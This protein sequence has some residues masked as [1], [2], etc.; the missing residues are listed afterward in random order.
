[1]LERWRALGLDPQPV[2]LEHDSLTTRGNAHCSAALL[3]RRQLTRVGI[4]TC[5]F[6]L[7]RALRYFGAEGLVVRGFAV[8]ARRGALTRAWLWGRERGALLLDPFAQRR[9]AHW[10]TPPSEHPQETETHQARPA[11]KQGLE[12]DDHR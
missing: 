4:V 7:P 11:A 5:D 12:T 3:R 8:P 9:G 6:H 2:L 1:M 10:L